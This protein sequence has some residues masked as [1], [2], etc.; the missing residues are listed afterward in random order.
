MAEDDKNK[1]TEALVAPALG[2]VAAGGVAAETLVMGNSATG[3]IVALLAMFPGAVQLAVAHAANAQSKRA[4]RLWEQYVK[5]FGGDAT[6][7]EAAGYVEAH[8]SEPHVYESVTA[9]VR[10]ML[11]AVS[12]EVVPVLGALAA[13]YSRDKVRPDAFFR[14][15]ARLV[16]ELSAAEYHQLRS[17]VRCAL[18]VRPTGPAIVQ[19]EF[20]GAGGDP[21]KVHI[22]SWVAGRVQHELVADAPDALRI[23]QLVKVSALGRDNPAGF[24]DTGLS[25]PQAVVFE[26]ETLKRIGEF[27]V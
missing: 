25:G 18:A 1:T 22:M 13:T 12:E 21:A 5:S 4:R 8:A 7:E 11:D 23:F 19:L 17:I 9:A 24:A 16:A 15:L 10:A 27:L 14:G 2:I 26:H 6:P 20:I 3:L